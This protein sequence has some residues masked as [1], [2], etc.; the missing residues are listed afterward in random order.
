MTL[1]YKGIEINYNTYGKGTP[2]VF[3]HGFLENSTMWNDIIPHF[4]NTHN[5]ITIDL[6]G[7]GKTDCLGY[8]HRMEDMAEAVRTVLYSIK[9][10]NPIF[11]GHSMGGYVSLAYL[12]LFP[13]LV[14]GLVLLNSTSFPDSE[15]RKTNRSRAIDIVKKN[16]KAYTG[17]AIANLFAE[18]NRDKYKN[19]VEFI[20]NEASK[21]PLQGIISALEGMKIRKDHTTTL[22]KFKK[23]K[24]IF[25][26]EKDPVLS[27]QQNIEE[28]KQCK[29]DLVS[30]NGG[31]MSYIENQDELLKTLDQFLQLS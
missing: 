29:T 25:A 8:I 20:K 5:C 9:I 3:L 7:H 2:L 4:S 12:D 27:Y 28:S 10:D 14:S 18:E 17:M 30:L 31:H 15:E 26:G 6:L 19:Q 23:P 11:I 16:P 24:I 21:M 22:L 1:A 13:K